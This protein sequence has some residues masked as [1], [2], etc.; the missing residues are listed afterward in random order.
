MKK[1]KT[2]AP[3]S[4]ALMAAAVFPIPKNREESENRQRIIDA[5]LKAEGY[6]QPEP[7]K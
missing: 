1:S 5:T 2:Y 6:Q 3:S 4:V 7:K